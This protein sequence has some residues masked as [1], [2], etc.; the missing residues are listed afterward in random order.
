[1]IREIFL[2]IEGGLHYFANRYPENKGQRYPPP[3]HYFISWVQFLHKFILI[4]EEQNLKFPLLNG[5][6]KFDIATMINMMNGSIYQNTHIKLIDALGVVTL[7]KDLQYLYLFKIP[8]YYK[9]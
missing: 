9:K 1:M 4:F 2:E 3:V 8:F 5:V 7:D 6:N